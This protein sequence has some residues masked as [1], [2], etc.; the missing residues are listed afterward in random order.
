MMSIQDM[1]HIISIQDLKHIISMQD[2]KHIICMQH[3]KHIKTSKAHHLYTTHDPLL[4]QHYI[5]LYTV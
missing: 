4:V 2:M 5:D 3:I 1:K